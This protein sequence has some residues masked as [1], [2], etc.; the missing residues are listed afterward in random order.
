MGVLLLMQILWFFGKKMAFA[1]SVLRSSSTT[2][3]LYSSQR[4]SK[5]RDLAASYQKGVKRICKHSFDLY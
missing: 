1:Y 3:L 4:V 2:P 5:I